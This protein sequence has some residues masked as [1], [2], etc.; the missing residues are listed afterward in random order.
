MS[1]GRTL[2]CPLLW[3]CRC[4]TPLF[5]AAGRAYDLAWSEAQEHQSL[6]VSDQKAHGH[7]LVH[8]AGN[9]NWAMAL[10]QLHCC[11]G[12]QPWEWWQYSK[13]SYQKGSLLLLGCEF[14][15]GFHSGDVRELSGGPFCIH[16]LQV[17]HHDCSI[18]NMSII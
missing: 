2:C 3:W 11:L 12:P 16:G 7:R 17:L 5:G 15:S 6:D 9:E 13:L 14:E 18:R 4:S 8:A 1:H 10:T